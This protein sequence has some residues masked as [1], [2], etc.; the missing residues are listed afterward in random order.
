[1]RNFLGTASSVTS[2]EKWL[3]ALAAGQTFSHSVN[4]LA[5]AAQNSHAQLR[6]PVGSGVTALVRIYYMSA[7]AASNVSL[8]FDNVALGTDNGFGINMLSGG[9]A[10]KCKVFST[11]N[12]GILGT[13]V[14]QFQVNASTPFIPFIEWLCQLAPGQGVDLALAVVNVSLLVTWKWMEQ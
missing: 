13:T 12:A 10:S 8:T 6:N 9:A 14:E 3:Q 11:T 4:V 1:V 2:T 7:G 5:V